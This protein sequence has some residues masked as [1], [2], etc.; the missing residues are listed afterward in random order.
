MDDK[1]YHYFAYGFIMGNI[2]IGLC[3]IV[4]D[5]FYLIYIGWLFITGAILAIFDKD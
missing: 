2:A 5:W 3:L 4:K 1:K